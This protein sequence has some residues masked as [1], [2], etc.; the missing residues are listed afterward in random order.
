MRFWVVG[1]AVLALSLSGCGEGRDTVAA[2]P[3]PYVKTWILQAAESSSYS[4]SGV[5]RARVESPLAFQVPGRIVARAVD[6]GQTVKKGVSLFQLDTRDLDEQYREAQAGVAA[7]RA[8][9][10]I[11]Q[12]DLTRHRQLLAGNA[13]SR[14][15]ADQAELV[16]QEAQARLQGAL[17]RQTQ[18][19]NALE[20]AR[21]LAPADG[22]LIDVTGDVGQVVAAGQ[23]VA[24]LAHAGEREIEV[25]FPQGEVPPRQGELSL[26]GQAVS[27]QLRESAGAVD[28]QS[29]TLRARYA[30]P[31]L[32]PALQLGSVQRLGFSSDDAGAN[33]FRVPVGALNERGDGPR[34][35]QLKDGIV[36]PV[37]VTL[38]RLDTETALIRAELQAGDTIVALGTH[39]LADGMAVREHG[40]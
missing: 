25:Y 17:A 35:W 39:L 4:L 19:K 34:V 33:T 9:Q 12:D 14:Q 24:L 40:K 3:A 37:Q 6:A 21:L 20:Y 22:V 11:A 13:V 27:V 8:A 18:A 30:L 16:L 5:V 28:A 26:D 36:T 29:R 7:A 10:R 1:L 32:A 15:A 38:L 23:T 31:A 2:P